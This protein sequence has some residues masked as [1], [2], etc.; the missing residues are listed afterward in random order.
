[1]CVN[2]MRSFRP[3]HRPVRRVLD[4]LIHGKKSP[5]L[6]V[7]TPEPAESVVKIEDDPVKVE[8]L[9]AASRLMEATENVFESVPGFT[10][11]DLLRR[12]TD[13]LGL[14]DEFLA[15]V[16]REIEVPRGS[17]GRT[18]HLTHQELVKL[19]VAFDHDRDLL[20]GVFALMQ[21]ELFVGEEWEGDK[22]P[23]DR[24][25]SQQERSD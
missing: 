3:S 22:T 20:A 18:L 5:E 17:D 25:I 9:S 15:V 10:K 24:E 1:M 13:L 7:T 4:R 2:G 23:G 12:S 11:T 8:L 16:K 21:Q 19:F 6:T 14:Y